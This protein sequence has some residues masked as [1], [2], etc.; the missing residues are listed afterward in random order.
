M[1]EL[2][3]SYPRGQLDLLRIGKALSREGFSSKQPPPRL[4]EVEPARPYGYEDLLHA[5]VVLQPLPDGRALVTR[6]IV[7]DQVKV[8]DRVRFGNHFEQSQVAF[9]IAQRGGER[10]SFAVAYPQRAVDPDFLGTPAV[11]QGRLEMRCPPGDQ[12]GAG[13]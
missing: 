10:E 11:L 1:V 4:L 7:G 9:G 6:K 5:R 3:G 13:G 2:L 8:A 12:P